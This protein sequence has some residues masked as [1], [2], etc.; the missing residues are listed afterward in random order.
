MKQVKSKIH[1]NDA[2]KKISNC[3]LDET[4]LGMVSESQIKSRSMKQE[5]R[6]AVRAQDR[7]MIVNI[8]QT[9]E[10]LIPTAFIQEERRRVAGY[11]H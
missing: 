6:S 10:L 8:K 1:C 4:S 2:I 11:G 3:G 9:G 7:R 5:L